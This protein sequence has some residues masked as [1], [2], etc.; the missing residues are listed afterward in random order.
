[1]DCSHYNG[2]ICM[3][4]QSNYYSKDCEKQDCEYYEG[5]VQNEKKSC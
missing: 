3:N 5:G 1:M 4:I 2:C